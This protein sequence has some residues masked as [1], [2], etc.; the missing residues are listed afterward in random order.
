M[1]R[2][3][4]CKEISGVK[5]NVNGLWST[6]ILNIYTVIYSFHICFTYFFFFL[7][8]I[9]M[10]KKYMVDIFWPVLQM[11]NLVSERSKGLPKTGLI[12]GLW[13]AFSFLTQFVAIVTPKKIIFSNWETPMSYRGQRKKKRW[14][15]TTKK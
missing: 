14:T 4:A 13:Q 12:D 11:S 7:V 3:Q 2:S 9:I 15:T 1:R 6:I 10:L 8:L 5:N